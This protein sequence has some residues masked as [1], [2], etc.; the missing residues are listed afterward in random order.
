[1]ALPPP[2]PRLLYKKLYVSPYS[3]LEQG[4]QLYQTVKKKQI[5]ALIIRIFGVLKPIQLYFFSTYIAQLSDT[6]YISAPNAILEG[7]G[8]TPLIKR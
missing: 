5:D 1:M 6:S 4:L 8:V 2:P 3:G 7:H